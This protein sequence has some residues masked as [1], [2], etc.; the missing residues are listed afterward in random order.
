M[1]RRL[2]AV[3]TPHGGPDRDP[4][5]AR[6]Q[7]IER[8]FSAL[9][10]ETVPDGDVCRATER[11]RTS[12]ND[13]RR[14]VS[15]PW[16][17]GG[18]SGW[19]E[20][21]Q[22]PRGCHPRARTAELHPGRLGGWT[23]TSDHVG[24]SYELLLL[25]YTERVLRAYRRDE[26]NVFRAIVWRTWHLA[27]DQTSRAFLHRLSPKDRRLVRTHERM[28]LPSQQ[29]RRAI[30]RNRTSPGEMISP[31]TRSE[32]IAPPRG[33]EPLPTPDRALFPTNQWRWHHRED[34]HLSRVEV[35]APRS[36]FERWQTV[37]VAGLAPAPSRVKAAHSAAELHPVESG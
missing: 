21:H 4:G 11:I 33:I 29:W 15:R 34:S 27:R 14:I 30:E 7:R 22:R 20:L 23:C 36:I 2:P 18:W 26:S 9:E 28:V 31:V 10:A 3:V 25:S 37:R 16:N 6:H 24:V 12:T 17:S 1:A 35:E 5:K 8:C 19:L 32:G 13:L